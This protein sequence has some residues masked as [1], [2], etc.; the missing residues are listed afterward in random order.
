MD[1]IAREFA[2]EAHHLFI[3]ARETHPE[4]ARGLYE[5]FE[6][7][8]EKV[9]RAKVLQERF[10]T[11]RKILVDDLDG[12]VHRQYAGVPNQSGV[13]DHTGHIAYKAGWTDAGDIRYGLSLALKTRDLKREGKGGTTYCRE[14]FVFRSRGLT[15]DDSKSLAQLGKLA[16]L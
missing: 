13:I 6:S 2:E 16:D 12:T 14:L 8:E 1:E 7:F 3:Y 15:P 11:P 9:Q 10:D 5:H 4:Y